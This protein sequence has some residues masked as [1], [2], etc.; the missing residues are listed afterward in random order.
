TSGA[1]AA[2][3][4]STGLNT[5]SAAVLRGALADTSGTGNGIG[6]ATYDPA[7]GVRLLN[8]S[9]QDTSSGYPASATT[10]NVRLNLT[11]NAAITGTT[12]NT[13]QLDNTSASAVTVTNTGSFL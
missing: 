2:L 7:V 4:G 13:L 11:G 12:T 5:T 6:F 3:S 1:F 10:T 9:E 8:G